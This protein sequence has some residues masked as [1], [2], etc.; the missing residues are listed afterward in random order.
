MIARCQSPH[1]P[2]RAIPVGRAIYLGTKPKA[3]ISLSLSAGTVYLKN[4]PAMQLIG[5]VFSGRFYNA[6][7]RLILRLGH[8]VLS[9]LRGALPKP[10]VDVLIQ[11]DALW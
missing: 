9:L 5:V 11:R 4:C 10:P 1:Q 8:P 7:R 6:H 2:G 3:S